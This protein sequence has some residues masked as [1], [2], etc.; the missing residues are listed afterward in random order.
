MWQIE[1]YRKLPV[2]LGVVLSQIGNRLG[3]EGHLHQIGKLV[4]LENL[5]WS[6]VLYK[7]KLGIDWENRAI[8]SYGNTGGGGMA[9]LN[10]AKVMAMKQGLVTYD[11]DIHQGV[12]GGDGVFFVVAFLELVYV[13]QKGYT[14]S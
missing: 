13:R 8:Y 9:V 3:K 10:S 2:E 6:Q 5:Q 14:P 12:D 1:K 7:V 4:V 11:I